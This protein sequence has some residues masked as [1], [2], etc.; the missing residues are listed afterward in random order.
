MISSLFLISSFLITSE[1]RYQRSVYKGYIQH[2][3]EVRNFYFIA[4]DSELG[5][6]QKK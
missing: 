3:N 1:N 4:Q 6:T 5:V 2:K